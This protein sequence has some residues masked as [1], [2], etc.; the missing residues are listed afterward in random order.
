MSIITLGNAA[1]SAGK[2][3]ST[4]ELSALS[5]QAGLSV[6]VVD[7]DA[8]ATATKWLDANPTPGHPTI[9][10]VL[11]A[12]LG[13]GHDVARR[14]I[15]H[16][17]SGVDVIPSTTSLDG[18]ANR[19]LGVTSPEKRL[20]LALTS[21]K[22]EYDLI[23]IDCPGALSVIT[24]GALIA[25]DKAVTVSVPT[26][27]EIEGVPRWLQLV[28]EIRIAENPTL[29]NVAIIP[30]MVP[31]SNGGKK[32]I[33]DMELLTTQWPT[34]CTPPIRRSVDVPTALAGHHP[35][36]TTSKVSK[37][38]EAVRVWLVDRGIL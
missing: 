20:K 28:D 24:V 33:E 29:E 10:D 8:Q 36:P 4:V 17:P 31:P 37:D 9:A 35:L 23:I 25:A 26:R 19:L 32:Y 22:Q 27:K 6:L 18:D 2:S 1:G 15:L 5:V 16:T 21:L 13:T 7:A 38:Y 3:T 30:C 11:L 14:A 34:Q 12:P